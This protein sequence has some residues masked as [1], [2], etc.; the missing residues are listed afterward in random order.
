LGKRSVRSAG[1]TSG[2]IEITLPAKLQLLAGID[3]HLIVRDG[4]RP[5]I[6]LQPD[7]S[8]AH[9][10]FRDLWLKLQ[11]GLVE[12][13]DIGD[14][15]TADFTLTL[16]APNHWQEQPPLICADALAVNHGRTEHRDDIAEPLTGILASLGIVAGRRLGLDGK[17]ALPFG[18]ALAYLVTGHFAGLGTDFERGLARQVFQEN[19]DIEHDP[20]S[21]FNQSTWQRFAP[22]LRRV[23]EQFRLWQDEPNTYAKASE[24]WHRALTAEMGI[25]V[26]GYV[27]VSYISD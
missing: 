15:S 8:S 16:F 23:Y 22:G 27:T 24:K 7:L 18:D 9:A 25:A 14:F 20:A 6:V 2:S 11:A 17:L 13:D 12:I 19:V 4:P 10:L 5:E 26:T 21:L 3:C 1:R